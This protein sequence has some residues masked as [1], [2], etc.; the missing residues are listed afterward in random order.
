MAMLDLPM[1]ILGPLELVE[2]SQRLGAR[3]RAS[4]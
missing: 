3:L 1:E 4:V 2:A